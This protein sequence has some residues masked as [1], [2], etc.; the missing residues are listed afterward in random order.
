MEAQKKGLGRGIASLIPVK[1]ERAIAVAAVAGEEDRSF[2]KVPIGQVAPNPLQPRKFF[3]EQKI[4]ELAGSIR[5]RGILHP[6]VVTRRADGSYE[7]VSGERRLRAARVAGL[8]EVPVIVREEAAPSELLELAIIENVQREDLDPIE[9]GAA[10]QELMDKFGYTQE[11]AAQKV[12]KDRATVANLLRLQKLPTKARQALQSGRISVG[13]A[14]ALLG[15]PEIEKQ[16]YFIDRIAD[17]GWSVRELEMRVAAKRV[18]KPGKRGREIK[19]LP[20]K[21]VSLLDNLRR[22]LGTQV[23]LVPSGEKGKI[24]IEYYSETD[25]DRLYQ[26]LTKQ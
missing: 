5:E 20:P 25:L 17:E 23:R 26:S 21:Y 13:H 7:L 8:E 12:G 15:V 11:Q 24:I 2:L 18:L 19:P 14:R 1:P 16:L 9:E 6:L 10:Y 4:N 22:R 3:D